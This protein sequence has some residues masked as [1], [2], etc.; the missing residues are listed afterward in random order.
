MPVT[1]STD[2]RWR[3]IRDDHG[4]GWR[5]VQSLGPG[6]HPVKPRFE[7]RT[8]THIVRDKGHTI[9]TT[10]LET[11]ATGLGRSRRHSTAGVLAPT[12]SCSSSMLYYWREMKGKQKGNDA[13]EVNRKEKQKAVGAT[14]PF[15]PTED[16]SPTQSWAVAPATSTSSSMGGQCEIAALG[17]KRFVWA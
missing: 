13:V 3:G 1:D 16:A 9:E 8:C 17:Q 6:L 12:S 5:T 15:R 14:V 11:A 7:G 2:L 10:A 4:R